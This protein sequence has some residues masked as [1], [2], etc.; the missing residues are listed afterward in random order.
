MAAIL[1]GHNSWPMVPSRSVTGPL[2][3]ILPVSTGGLATVTSL[4]LLSVSQLEYCHHTP[5]NYQGCQFSGK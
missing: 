5:D 1:W 3:A 4:Q 2:M